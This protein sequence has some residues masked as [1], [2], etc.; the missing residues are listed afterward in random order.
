MQFIFIVGNY[1]IMSIT[2]EIKRQQG[3]YILQVYVP[4][5][6]LVFLSWIIFFMNPDQIGDRLAIGVT[7]ILT[8]IFLLGYVNGSLP[9]VSY[10]KAIDWY[11]ISALLLISMSLVETVFVYWHW[12]QFSQLDM[13]EVSIYK[14]KHRELSNLIN[15][16]YEL[17]YLI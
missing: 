6:I 4:C 17:S 13:K 3:F 9:K 12:M 10:I 2:I 14:K 16:S 8:M 7:L 15:T 1:T 5:I 11:M